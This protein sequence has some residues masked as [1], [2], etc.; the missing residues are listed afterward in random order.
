MTPKL[1]AK[2][3]VAAGLAAF[4]SCSNEAEKLPDPVNASCTASRVGPP[5][6]RRLT[7]AELQ[8]TVSDIFPSISASWTGVKLGADPVS[9]TGFSNDGAV[10]LVNQQTAQE[11]LDTAEDVAKLVSDSSQLPSILPCSTRKPD[12]ACATTFVTKYGRRLFRRALTSAEVQS[13]VAF[14]TSVAGRSDFSS[15][16]KWTLVTMMQ[17]PHAIY[18]SEIGT[19]SEDGFALSQQEIATNLAYTFGGSTPSTELLDKAERGELATSAA[20]LSEARA[21][22]DTPRGKDVLKQFFRAWLR[23]DR[24]ANSTQPMTPGFDT[25][26]SEMV[27]ETSRYIDQVVFTEKA[28]VSRLLTAPYT[29]MNSDL[30][31]F[32]GYGT[33]SG[34]YTQVQRPPEWGVGVLA[35]GAILAG[36]SHTGSTSPTQRGLLIYEKFLCNTRPKPPA[37]IPSISEPQPG[38]KTTR[39]RYESLHAKSDSCSGCHKLWD[40]IGFSFEHFDAVGRYRKDEGGLPIDDS[41]RVQTG[42]DRVLMEFKGIGELATALSSHSEVSDCAGNLMATYAYGGGGGQ[43]CL[44]YDSLAGFS[45]GEFGFTEFMVRLASAPHF[46]KRK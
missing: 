22:L 28:G 8:N 13:Y 7:R 12:A 32:Y 6:L 45:S 34:S 44:A 40:P 43:S 19:A 42:G 29:Y 1:T 30:A 39:E 37:N 31:T 24:A 4:A 23:Y 11:V 18:R 15:G 36:Y 20:L 33:A 5:T 26:K 38:A 10:L 14:H 3:F 25:I 17:S 16:I 27:E 35:Q 2:I 41:G 46:T 9:K 21:L